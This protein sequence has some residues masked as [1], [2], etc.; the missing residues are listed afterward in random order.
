MLIVKRGDSTDKIYFIKAGTVDVEVPLKNKEKMKFE[1]LNPGSCF[2][3]FSAF[4]EDKKQKFDFRSRTVCV[5]ESI[6]AK[7][8]IGL[9]KEYLELSDEIKTL[10][11]QIENNEKSEFDFFR[12]LP[13][14][15]SGQF[16]E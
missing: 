4:H 14:R 15:P 5:V 7:D 3:I 13:K 12:Y 9:Q 10:M 11:V 1:S 8:I 6:L 16:D 2:C